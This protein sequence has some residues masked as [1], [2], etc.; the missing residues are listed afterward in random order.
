MPRGYPGTVKPEPVSGKE[1][2]GKPKRKPRGKPF[3][4]GNTIGAAGRPPG[5]PNKMT[6]E[7][8]EAWLAAAELAGGPGGLVAYLLAQAQ[9]ANPS[10]FMAGL[11]QMI[12][13][14]IEAKVDATLVVEVVKF[15]DAADA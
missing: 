2:A 13:Q 10:P 9:Q 5:V 12:P 1:A 4:P 6:R 7:I 3:E 11:K 14:E 15:T 8:K